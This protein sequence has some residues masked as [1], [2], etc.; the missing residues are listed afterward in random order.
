MERPLVGTTHYY[1][2]ISMQA[3]YKPSRVFRNFAV[4]SFVLLL[5][6]GI[7]LTQFSYQVAMDNVIAASE[8]HHMAV[9][10]IIINRLWS[11]YEEL[12]ISPDL[13]DAEMLR[14]HIKAHGSQEFLKT[15][16]AGTAVIKIKIYNLI[17]QIIYS[18]EMNDV[19]VDEANNPDFLSAKDGVVTSR[20]LSLDNTPLDKVSS[21]ENNILSSFIPIRTD[22]GRVR[23]VIAIYGDISHMKHKV[24]S[25]QK[26]LII[27][28]VITSCLLFIILLVFAFVTYIEIKSQNETIRNQAIIDTLTGLPNR[29]LFI[30]SLAHALE[31]ARNDR[32]LVALILF[33]LDHFKQI[34][35]LFG[36]DMG[37][38][39]LSNI[40]KRFAKDIASN[41]ILARL[42]GD[43]FA[44]IF[45]DRLCF[46]W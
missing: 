42:G 13:Q 9:E 34:N 16:L 4:C 40:T 27:G 31:W 33:D 29:A 28:I 3:R 36:H 6:S 43:E 21:H 19:G 45:E 26:N 25:F 10:R 11:N 23:G 44:V 38:V 37:D 17:G 8:G 22:Q 18:S 2:L 39:L 41:G 35:D 46:G 15:E 1:R 24:D 20:L 30:D 5:I 12:L 32:K 14:S 7:A